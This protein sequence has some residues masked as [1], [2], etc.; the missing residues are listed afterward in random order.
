MKA[1]LQVKN[2]KTP[3]LANRQ[4]VDQFTLTRILNHAE[5]IFNQNPQHDA[6]EAHRFFQKDS[7]SHWRLSR[8]EE[9]LVCDR[10][11]FTTIFYE[12]GT[13]AANVGLTE[14]DDPE[15]LKLLKYDYSRNK[16]ELR[17]TT[18]YIFGTL[19]TKAHNQKQFERRLKMLRTP[20]FGLLSVCQQ[21]DFCYK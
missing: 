21:E 1:L 5:L 12:R 16:I 9:C 13:L 8:A 2:Y 19:V 20:I 18:P 11:A 4:S 7:Q 15:V 10:H 14:I 17:N 3:H 6:D